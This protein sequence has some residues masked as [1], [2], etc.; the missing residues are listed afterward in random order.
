M[1]YIFYYLGHLNIHFLFQIF[2]LEFLK[3]S[4]VKEFWT[5]ETVGKPKTHNSNGSEYGLC[6][7]LCKGLTHYL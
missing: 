1:R 2:L 7:Y 6:G 5:P 3:Q 4:T